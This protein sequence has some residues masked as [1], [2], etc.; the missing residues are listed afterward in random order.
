M[1]KETDDE[2]KHEIE[3]KETV[4]PEEYKNADKEVC[5]EIFQHIL[6]LTQQYMGNLQQITHTYK[7]E[8]ARINFAFV[9]GIRGIDRPVCSAFG[10]RTKDIKLELL[11]LIQQVTERTSKAKKEDKD[12]ENEED[13]DKDAKDDE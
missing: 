5:A 7:A 1:I 10:G 4:T 8:L 3:Q 2:F 9:V 6:E 12:E 13:A 11:D